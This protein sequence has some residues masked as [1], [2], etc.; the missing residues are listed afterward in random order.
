MHEDL[1]ALRSVAPWWKRYVERKRLKPL[2]KDFEPGPI[3]L[4]NDPRMSE[5]EAEQRANVI[6]AN[7]LTS[8]KPYPKWQRHF[9]GV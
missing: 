4:A 7:S 8:P 1:S 9:L 3:Y 2:L 5:A 6:M